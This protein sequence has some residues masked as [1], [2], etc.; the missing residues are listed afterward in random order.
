VIVVDAYDKSRRSAAGASD[1][2]GPG[3]GLEVASESIIQD[4]DRKTFQYMAR[5]TE[6]SPPAAWDGNSIIQTPLPHVTH[7]VI[8]AE[9]GFRVFRFIAWTF[10]FLICDHENLRLE[11]HL[12]D[13][14][15]F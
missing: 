6:K 13:E 1:L 14:S 7:V 11:A 3:N 8:G 12:V 10:H 4:L 9:W 15:T 5:R 2:V